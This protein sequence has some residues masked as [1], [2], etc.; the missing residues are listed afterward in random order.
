MKNKENIE[1]IYQLSPIQEGMLF[2]SI[3]DDTSSPYIEQFS[4]KLIGNIDLQLFEESFNR[5]V[6]RYEILRTA[7]VYEETK[8]PLQVV[9]KE[10]KVAFKYEDIRDLPPVKQ[11]HYVDASKTSNERNRFDLKNDSLM[12]V[13]LI[14]TDHVT[15]ELIWSWHHII[16]DG[17][18]MPIIFH[19]FARI[20]NGGLRKQ[21]VNLP[22]TQRFKN[23]VAWLAKKP[24]EE[25]K[26]YWNNYI[27]GYESIQSLTPLT[28]D[29]KTP[30]D[31]VFAKEIF[32][33]D[34]A[35]TQKLIALSKKYNTTINGVLQ[36]IW[37]VLMNRYN[38]R[39]DL[40]FGSVVSGRPTEIPGIAS[41]VGVF[42]NTIPVRIQYDSAASFSDLLEQYREGFQQSLPHSYY[43]LGRIQA[44]NRFT[45]EGL[46][47]HILVFENYPEVKVNEDEEKVDGQFEISDVQESAY[48]NY[49]FVLEINFRE[50][51][52]FKYEYNESLYD[53]HKVSRMA[54]HY[55]GLIEQ[56]LQ[57]EMVAIGHL[58]IVTGVEREEL[59]SGFSIAEKMDIPVPS[60][61]S[62][63]EAQ[64]AAGP[65]RIAL[66]GENGTFTFEQV[67]ADANRIAHYLLTHH[68]V[69]PDKLIGLCI[70]RSELMVA[71]ILGILKAGAA[72]VPIDPMDPARRREYFIENAKLDLVLLDTENATTVSAH[73]RLITVSINQVLSQEEGELPDGNPG[74]DIEQSQLAY[75]MFTSGST[76]KPKGVMIE[77]GSLMALQQ[78][79]KSRFSISSDDKVVAMSKFTFDISV[80]ELVFSLSV[81]ARVLLV[82]EKVAGKGDDLLRLIADEQP[83]FLQLTPSHLSLLLEEDSWEALRILR[84]LLLGGEIISAK[85]FEALESLGVPTILNGY[86]PTECTIYSTNTVI[87][88]DERLMIGKPLHNERIYIVDE[89]GLLLPRGIVGEI[90]IGGDGVAR[91][92][93]FNESLTAQK[94]VDDPTQP[95]SKMYMTGDL[96]EWDE[97]GNII[98]HGRRD[99]QI[100]IN[101]YR[102]ELGEIEKHLIDQPSVNNAILK[103]WED[104]EANTQL[105]AYLV[106]EE[107]E[108]VT[109]EDRQAEEE[110]HSEAVKVISEDEKRL[111]ASFNETD[112]DFDTDVNFHEIF[113]RQVLTNP[114]KLAITDGNMNLTYGELNA[115][116]NQ[117]AHQLLSCGLTHEAPVIVMMERSSMM[118]TTIL[119]IFKAGGAYLP[120]SE[121][122]P[123]ARIV[124]LFADSQSKYLLTSAAF[125]DSNLLYAIQQEVP[126]LHVLTV[127]DFAAKA[128]V[129]AGLN[130]SFLLSALKGE[131]GKVDRKQG[132]QYQFATSP[133]SDQVDLIDESVL[134]GQVAYLKEKIGNAGKVT[135][136]GILLKND[137]YQCIALM[138]LQDLGI[139]YQLMAAFDTY[140]DSSKVVEEHEIDCLISEGAMIDAADFLRWDQD[141]LKEVL[142][143]D[144]YDPTVSQSTK[145]RD[146]LDIWN[147]V[148]ESSHTDINDYGWNNSYTGEPFTEAEMVEYVDNFKEK[149]SGYLSGK[150]RVLE[151]GCGH[152][153]VMFNLAPNTKEYVAT[154]LSDVIIE[155]NRAKLKE[156]GLDH[157]SVEPY[158]AIEVAKVQSANKFDA[159]V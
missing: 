2:H 136:V 57:D 128:Q 38:A 100:Q 154:D 15:Y 39:E 16:M 8:I 50:K 99:D 43:P 114:D 26:N 102:I 151:I 150:E 4:C 104:Q 65:D 145:E 123:L 72:Y 141:G 55:K 84:V 111:L 47:D 98:F 11:G 37:G 152:G 116:A 74:L 87:Q 143:L 66:I 3:Y 88:P 101:G 19:D 76:G 113:E 149:M 133:G 85:T 73:D 29:Q 25:T 157:V 103:P 10:R 78:N 31:P 106:R 13:H 64:V 5:V 41:M 46:F 146:F 137:Y 12:R 62:L 67:N 52:Q 155:K 91:G 17:W 80:M 21:T 58:E 75:V 132:N 23:Y 69:K 35:R 126:S 70:N 20:Y 68:E 89:A 86:G 28:K 138:A 110:T 156:R 24:E 129:Q 92:Y 36:C 147:H 71:G 95:G 27:E 53:R 159:V 107:E 22:E 120:I 94:F 140:S 83:T 56:V 30:G 44:N 96:A 134:L 51:I 121:E 77:H 40:I 48:T 60:V 153:L 158:S 54:D 142:I 118:L 49:D 127:D 93:L 119:G 79:L 112:I 117:V 61:I 109:V 33:L 139:Q 6:A 32:Q 7:F 122:Y 131:A 1:D 97:Q 42:I 18:S 14:Q 115:R 81:G 45:E 82:S 108:E 125:V 9:L 135:S 148:A 124:E 34:I 90:A 59:L 63:F 130:T 105:I 144:Q